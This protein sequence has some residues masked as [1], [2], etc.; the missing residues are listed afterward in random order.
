MPQPRIGGRWHTLG[1]ELPIRP[2]QLVPVLL[3]SGV[4]PE[5]VSSFCAW[6]LFSPPSTQKSLSFQ[7]V[8]GVIGGLSSAKVN[9]HPHQRNRGRLSR[10]IQLVESARNSRS[11]TIMALRAHV[12]RLVVCWQQ[13]RLKSL[14]RTS[15]Q[16]LL[17]GMTPPRHRGLAFSCHLQYSAP[18]P[19]CHQ[20]G[21]DLR[22]AKR[23]AF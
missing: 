9:H 3:L 17:S 6:A 7:I 2:Q 4:S 21:V 5:V 19:H 18:G 1:R 22:Y 8:L 11:G 20:F 12:L 15:L 14:L 10:C 23:T 16:F 13:R